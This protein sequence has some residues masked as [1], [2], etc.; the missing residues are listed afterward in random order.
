MSKFPF[1]IASKRIKYLGIQVAKDANDLFKNNYKPLAQ[2]ERT[3]TDGETFHAH[4]QEE[5]IL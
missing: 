1:T 4:G 3:Q 5:S 2:E